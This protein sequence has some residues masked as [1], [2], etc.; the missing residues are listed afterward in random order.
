MQG[1]FLCCANV[2]ILG[3]CGADGQSENSFAVQAAWY[4]NATET[5]TTTMTAASRSFLGADAS[6]RNGAGAGQAEPPSS[7]D[8]A[9]RSSNE[10]DDVLEGESAAWVKVTVP[11]P[12]PR[13][14]WSGCPCM[15]RWRL[16]GFESVQVIEYCGNP[17]ND[18]GG[19]WCFVEDAVCQPQ[20]NWGYCAPAP[21]CKVGDAILAPG[22]SGRPQPGSLEEYRGLFAVVRWLDGSINLLPAKKVTTRGGIPCLH[23]RPPS[24]SPSVAQRLTG[25]T[26]TT[27]SFYKGMRF[28]SLTTT[29]TSSTFRTSLQSFTTIRGYVK[30]AMSA[31]S[32]TTSTSQ[33]SS[34]LA[35]SDTTS[36]SWWPAFHVGKHGHAFA[37][38][39]DWDFT[40]VMQQK[41][42]FEASLKEA[43][44]AVVREPRQAVE[45]LAIMRGSVIVAIGVVPSACRDE[46][47]QDAGCTRALLIARQRWEI[48]LWDPRSPLR[49]LLGIVDP[50]FPALLDAS[51][52]VRRGLVC[53]WLPQT[54]GGHDCKSFGRCPEARQ[55]DQAT[56]KRDPWWFMSLIAFAGATPT[57]LCFGMFM[58]KAS[59]RLCRCIRQRRH[60]R[61]VREDACAI[62]RVELRVEDL[63]L[64]EDWVCAI[65]L[66]ELQPEG[67]LLLLPCK[68]TLHYEC[69]FEWFERRLTCP[70]CRTPFRMR[71]CAIYTTPSFV[72][73]FEAVDDDEESIQDDDITALG[74]SAAGA[75][76]ERERLLP[77]PLPNAVVDEDEPEPWWTALPS[78]LAN[79]A[80][81]SVQE[82]SD[83]V[84]G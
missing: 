9:T 64:G 42:S 51:E 4:G 18:L 21:V 26:S 39:I 32:T 61:E 37:L 43:A 48:A 82:C 31:T 44:A 2:F 36:K 19:D 5:T 74:A 7:T 25:R 41:A 68:H 14:T 60:V 45:V 23:S 84:I 65:C 56:N 66:G 52:C 27:T 80:C 79:R 71:D 46:D 49:R 81:P 16:I 73:P 38:R 1:L 33:A 10:T 50:M 62:P 83:F 29:G 63:H 72:T 24:T 6:L 22:P 76:E 35:G 58:L 59:F 8:N 30:K 13:Y 40:K 77:P 20:M 12:T 15:R 34:L 78:T 11:A 57:C 69:S 54:P 55:Q 67:D 53:P 47:S 70:M 17:D 75:S 28:D 3:C